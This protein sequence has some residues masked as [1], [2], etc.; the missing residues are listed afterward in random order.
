MGSIL[1]STRL[2]FDVEKRKDEGSSHSVPA[3]NLHPRRMEVEILG[4]PRIRRSCLSPRSTP[5]ILEIDISP[6][7][8]LGGVGG[9]KS[10]EVE[11]ESTLDEVVQ[12]KVYSFNSQEE[13]LEAHEDEFSVAYLGK[14]NKRV[15]LEGGKL[16]GKK[17]SVYDDE[18][19]STKVNLSKRSRRE[20]FGSRHLSVCGDS[21]SNGVLGSEEHE[22]LILVEEWLF[23][24]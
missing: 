6:R 21:S 10:M 24:K 11:W 16:V 15:Y 5:I 23:E 20:D 13:I 14:Q 4:E 19:Y 17:R 2:Y 22:D 8:C 12:S 3:K 7:V 18:F 1:G 9:S